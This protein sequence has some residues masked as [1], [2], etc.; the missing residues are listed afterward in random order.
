MLRLVRM[1]RVVSRDYF[2][3]INPF[4]ENIS[5]FAGQI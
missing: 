3:R 4:N 2:F 5:I 1:D